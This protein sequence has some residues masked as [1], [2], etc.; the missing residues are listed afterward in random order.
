MIQKL[1]CLIT[2]LKAESD[3]FIQHLRLKR[4]SALDFPYFVNQKLNV[5]LIGVGVGKK[6]IRSRIN[7]LFKLINHKEVQFINVGIAGGK[8]S[9]TNIG[10]LFIINKILDDNSDKKYYPEIII[11]HGLNESS[12]TTVGAPVHDGGKKYDTLVDMEAHEIFSTC[13]RLVPVHNISIIKLVSDHMDGQELFSQPSMVSE[14]LKEKM[15]EIIHFINQFK[16]IDEM[17]RPILLKKDMVWIEN[18]KGKY[19]LTASQVDQL[20]KYAKGYRLRNNE[21]QLPEL[22]IQIPTTKNNQKNTFNIICEKL[23][24]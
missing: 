9:R 1:Q 5:G 8:K 4:D 12:I 15:D 11:D 18:T 2:A 21:N 14:L 17:V 22:D 6:N 19:L 3:P 13:S 24:T 16:L 7:D 20:I 23:K 10:D